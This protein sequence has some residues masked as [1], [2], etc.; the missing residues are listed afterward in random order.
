MIAAVLAAPSTQVTAWAWKLL[1]AMVRAPRI[2]WNAPANRNDLLGCSAAQ[3][4]AASVAV[5]A[6]MQR[7][8]VQDGVWTRLEPRKLTQ[9]E[10]L[11][12][13]IAAGGQCAY[14][15]TMTTLETFHADH[16]R[17]VAQGGSDD[18]ENLACACGPCNQSKG[19]R[20]PEQWR[21]EAC[22]LEV[23]P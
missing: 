1:T 20:T 10:R 8:L 19:A 7:L 18:P 12:V 13:F 4:F 5:E 2:D 11:A 3:W 9:D 14:C 21:G 23:L 17:P 16:V 22:P 6:E 15:P